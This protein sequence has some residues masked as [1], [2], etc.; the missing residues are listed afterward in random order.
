MEFL[1]FDQTYFDDFLE[2]SMDLWKDFEKNELESILREIEASKNK[3]V[4]FA[5]VDETLVGFVYVSIRYDHVEGAN[6]TPTGYL[7]GIYVKP[8]YQKK[9]IAQ[10]LFEL[11]EKWTAQK[12]CRQIGSDT[13]EWNKSSIAFH[14]KIGFEEEDTLVHFIKNIDLDT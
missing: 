9:G 4:F 7:E 2:M 10:G 3:E 8:P 14:K 13:W 1:L 6:S 12:G 11:A 5:K